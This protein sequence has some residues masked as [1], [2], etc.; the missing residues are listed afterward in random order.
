M[1]VQ[2]AAMTPP[3]RRLDSIASHLLLPATSSA[4]TPPKPIAKSFYAPNRPS[5]DRQ[6]YISGALH[7]ETEAV[8]SIFDTA[9]TL[10]DQITDSSRTFNH[11][12]FKLE[13][14]ISR[15]Y[16]SAKAARIDIGITQAEMMRI[17]LEL[18]EN[19][20]KMLKPHEDCWINHQISRGGG[21]DAA[22]TTPEGRAL[23]N[24]SATIIIQNTFMDLV[25]TKYRAIPAQS[26]SGRGVLCRLK[27]HAV[28]A[29]RR[30]SGQTSTQAA[31]TESPPFPA[32]SHRSQLTLGSKIVAASPT[33]WLSSK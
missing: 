29:A 25:R 9:V 8:L 14:H 6:V 24:G 15:I 3:R 7:K 11:K 31:A 1:L 10:G 13:Q 16:D 33:H 2:Q 18:L 26:I 5:A 28:V 21:P 27:S 23:N 19:N 17:T 22:Q 20:L 4:E 32:P 30:P 12:P